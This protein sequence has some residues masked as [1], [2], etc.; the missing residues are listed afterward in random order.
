MDFP[1]PL[2]VCNHINALIHFDDAIIFRWLEIARGNNQ[3][4]FIHP[5][6]DQ[7]RRR[8]ASPFKHA[9]TQSRSSYASSNNRSSMSSSVFSTPFSRN[10]IA[11]SASSISQASSPHVTLHEKVRLPS[12]SGNF[13]YAKYQR[14]EDSYAPSLR[15]TSSS[16]SLATDASLTRPSSRASRSFDYPPK[17]QIFTCTS[18]EVKFTRKWDWKHH[19]EEYH[20]RWRKWPCP[21]CIQV[22]FSENK[23]RQ[24]HRMAHNCEKCPHA[25]GAVVLLEKKSAW[26]CGFCGV[27]LSTWEERCNHIAAHFEQREG[28]EKWEYGRVIMGLLSQPE[29]RPVWEALIFRLHGERDPWFGYFK[30]DKKS[31]GKALEDL[32]YNRPTRDIEHLVQTAYNIGYRA[33]CLTPEL[34]RNNQPPVNKPL[35]QPPSDDSETPQNLDTPA[36]LKFEHKSTQEHCQH[37]SSAAS[38]VLQFSHDTPQ[39]Q[40]QQQH[41]QQQPESL[42]STVDEWQRNTHPQ[43][44]HQDIYFCLSDM[45]EVEENTHDYLQNHPGLFDQVRM[46]LAEGQHHQSHDHQQQAHTGAGA[47]VYGQGMEID[48]WTK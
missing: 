39:P 34:A 33:N 30:W 37:P 3:G 35:P 28:K 10:S 19:E 31:V 22:F 41:H 29:V 48:D 14:R 38:M 18:C 9:T 12:T 32:E 45:G 4:P 46:E 26:G 40:H 2:E 17:E 20:E 44:V 42:L 7:G 13:Q 11:S 6:I 43:S 5:S 16:I 25:K 23:L 15:S 36:P 21:D 27:P 24:H 47:M 8:N 1:I